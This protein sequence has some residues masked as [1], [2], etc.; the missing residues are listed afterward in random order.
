ML[1]QERGDDTGEDQPS[2]GPGGGEDN[3]DEADRGGVRL[4]P[5]FDVP[6]PVE[7]FELLQM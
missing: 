6:L 4:E 1:R 5:S 7:L 2:A 3:R